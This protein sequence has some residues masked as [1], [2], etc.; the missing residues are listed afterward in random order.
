MQSIPV[1]IYHHILP[2]SGF[3]TV[4]KENFKD[5]LNTIKK[6]GWHTL[7]A[8][9][10][11]DFKLKGYKPPK[12]SLLITFDDGWLDN[13]IYA[14]PLLKEYGFKAT[15]FVVT[16][17]INRAPLKGNDKLSYA[18]H[19]ESNKR[20]KAG[21]AGAVFNIDQ[22]IKSSDVFDFH[23]HTHTHTNRVEN[24]V[25]FAKELEESQRFFVT[26]F[27][28][29]SEHLCHPWG[30]YE[31]SDEELIKGTGFKLAYTVEN[32]S[33]T[34]KDHPFYIKRF[35]IK[36]RGGAWLSSKLALYSN[37][38]LARIYGRYKRF[39]SIL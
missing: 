23:S 32:G 22:M 38:F 10:F 37:P 9:E 35:T 29:K 39:K 6:E 11:L 19:K 16:D 28:K 3:I 2:Q 30:Y 13:L 34:I 18:N 7:S 20:A 24:S 8:D 25:N 26:H 31:Q 4:S 5:Q 12:K 33:N 1:L 17:W 14:Y 15:V 21:E 36:D 27:G